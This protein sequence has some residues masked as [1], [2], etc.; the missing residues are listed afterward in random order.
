MRGV[1]FQ[2]EH[3]VIWTFRNHLIRMWIFSLSIRT[4]LANT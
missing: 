1:I 4:M 3:D 2:I